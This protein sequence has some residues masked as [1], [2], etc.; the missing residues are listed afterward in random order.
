M[1]INK[2]LRFVPAT[3]KHARQCFI[4][5]RDPVGKN[6][7]AAEYHPDESKDSASVYC[8][9]C[10]REMYRCAMPNRSGVKR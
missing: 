8:S 3:K 6:A 9:T 10:V 1:G 5:G 7:V 2:T 4:C